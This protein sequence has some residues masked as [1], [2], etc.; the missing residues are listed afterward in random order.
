MGAEVGMVV[1]SVVMGPGECPTCAPISMKYAN[2]LLLTDLARRV[3]NE[4]TALQV[5]LTNGHLDVAFNRAETMIFYLNGL[6][7]RLNDIKYNRL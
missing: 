3:T 5:M 2:D 7:E 4:N 1:G 6:L